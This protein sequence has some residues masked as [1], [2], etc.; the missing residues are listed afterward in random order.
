MVF[1]LFLLARIQQGSKEEPVVSRLLS[2]ES[3]WSLG[4]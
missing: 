3:L 4:F 2:G 1:P